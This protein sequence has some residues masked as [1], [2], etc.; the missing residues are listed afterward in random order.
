MSRLGDWQIPGLSCNPG[1]LITSSYATA[2]GL[3]F[4]HPNGLFIKV[5]NQ[6]ILPK[7]DTFQ[8]KAKFYRPRFRIGLPMSTVTAQRSVV[9]HWVRSWSRCKQVP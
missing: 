6:G 3:R 8:F 5:C 7:S 1:H 4:Q 9:G 2:P